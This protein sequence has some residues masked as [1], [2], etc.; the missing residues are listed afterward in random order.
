M[1]LTVKPINLFDNSFTY[2]Q[3]KTTLVGKITTKTLA[4]KTVIGPPIVKYRNTITGP[5][6]ITPL[7]VTITEN[8][9]MFVATAET[10]GIVTIALY[11]LMA[12]N[13]DM[14]YVGKIN[15]QIPEPPTTTYVV[16]GFKVL[17]N[18]TTG[19]KIF[20]LVTANVAGHN[21]LYMVDG[22]GLSDFLFIPITVPTA[23]APS[24]KA[25]YKLDDSPFTLNNGAGL[26]LDIA[27]TRVYVQR[28]VAATM[29]F[30]VFNYGATITTVGALGATTDLYLFATGNLPALA[31]VLLLTNSIDYTVPT[32]GPNASQPC[33]IFHTTTTMYRGRLS[34]L[35]T[36][37]T[38]WPSLEF[39]NNLGEV[40]EFLSATRLARDLCPENESPRE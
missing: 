39:A 31:G 16:R 11:D 5:E 27:N 24:Q 10:S 12:S 33:V 37:A 9:R 18:G 20:I 6:A 8:N 34:D 2:D 3:T 32:S 14:N 13:G 22:I 35:T 17:D 38:T 1:S 4:G 40:N 26:M 36:G 23:T 30:L 21:G 29:Q 19:W 15:I 28:G 7:E 25:V